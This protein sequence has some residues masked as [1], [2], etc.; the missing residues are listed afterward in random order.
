MVAL[1]AALQPRRAGT[2]LRSPHCPQVVHVVHHEL[3]SESSWV[4]WEGRGV[5]ELA[6]SV[7][8]SPIQMKRLSGSPM[9]Y[10]NTLAMAH[11]LAGIP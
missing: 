9:F 2:L 6:K 5:A 7:V 4:G 3:I 10:P 11:A 8:G 1:S